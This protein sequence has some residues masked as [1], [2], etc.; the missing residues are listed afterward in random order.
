[1]GDISTNF[2]WFEF[3]CHDN[4]PVPPMYKDNVKRL[5][6][7][8]LQPL[9]DALGMPIKI[10]SG[11][12]TPEYN[13]NCGGVENSQHLLGRAADIDIVGLSAEEANHVVRGYMI[14]RHTF[15]EQGGGVGWYKGFTHVDIRVGDRVSFWDKT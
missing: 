1:M 15:T 8:V 12:R 5:V 11:Y 7:E 14:G 10:T 9:R 3:D 13:K 6:T 2:S 4:T